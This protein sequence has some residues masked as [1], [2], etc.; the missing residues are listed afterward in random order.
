MQIFEYPYIIITIFV[1]CFIVLGAVGIYFAIKGVRTA[2]DSI[3][4][5]FTN[6]SKIENSFKKSEKY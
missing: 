1:F 4:K 6:L 2:N 5:D 3:G